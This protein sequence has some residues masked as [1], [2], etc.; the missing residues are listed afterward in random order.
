MTAAV[1]KGKYLVSPSCK[2]RYFGQIAEMTVK[3]AVR[4][5]Y[6]PPEAVI[7]FIMIIKPGVLIAALLRKCNRIAYKPLIILKVR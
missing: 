2:I 7:A 4:E 3:Y 5:N 1:V 6:K